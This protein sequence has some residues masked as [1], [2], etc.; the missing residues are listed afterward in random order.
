MRI[1][2]ESVPEEQETRSKSFDE[3]VEEALN[4]PEALKKLKAEELRPQSLLEKIIL[5]KWTAPIIGAAMGIHNF[6]NIPAES[7]NLVTVFILGGFGYLTASLSK[8][9]LIT[10]RAEDAPGKHR[11]LPSKLLH[12][13]SDHPELTAA[14]V[15]AYA[16]AA[17]VSPMYVSIFPS[18]ILKNPKFLLP[19]IDASVSVFSSVFTLAYPA[20]SF[21]LGRV[22]HPETGKTLV[23]AAAAAF[24]ALTYRHEKAAR[25]L[26][27]LAGVQRS[28]K[29]AIT[30]QTLIGDF[31]LLSEDKAYFEAFTEAVSIGKSYGPGRSDWLLNQFIRLLKIRVRN[32]KKP[33]WAEA[34]D[35]A[36]LRAAAYALSEGKVEAADSLLKSAVRSGE[37]SIVAHEARAG[38]LRRTG[39]QLTADLEMR[40][41]AELALKQESLD[42]EQVEGT[43]NRVLKKGR[44]VLKLNKEAA[45]LDAEQQVTRRFRER[46]GQEIIYPLPIFR[47]GSDY[48]LLSERDIPYS[49]LDLMMQRKARLEDFIKAQALLARVQKF[50]Y[51]LYRRGELPLDD[52][53]LRINFSEPETL[54][55][56]NRRILAMQ[57]VELHNGVKLPESYKDAIAR[58]LLFVDRRIAAYPHLAMSKDHN[59]G[60][61]LIS[62][63]GRAQLL[64][65]ERQSLRLMPPQTDA[66]ALLE[67]APY[68]SPQQIKWILGRTI[69]DFEHANGVKVDRDLFFLTYEDVAMQWHFERLIYRTAEAASAK[70]DAVREVKLEQQVR[71]LMASRRHLRTIVDE[72]YEEGTE[73]ESAKRALEQLEQPIFADRNEY[74]R[75]CR[76]VEREEKELLT[77]EHLP[78][79]NA[80]L[81]LVSGY[82][83][84]VL[85]AL[86]IG[87]VSIRNNLVPVANIPVNPQ[88]DK[89]MLAVSSTE[90]I[91]GYDRKVTGPGK[92]KSYVIDAHTDEVSFLTVMDTVGID[93]SAFQDKAAMIRNGHLTLYDFIKKEFRVVEDERFETP[94]ISPN[95]LWIA[96]TLMTHYF[97]PTELWLIRPSDMKTKRA[98]TFPHAFLPLP[99]K[100]SWSPD[101]TYL[102]FLSR[103]ENGRGESS[104]YWKVWINSLK[105]S[106]GEVHEGPLI[107]RTGYG[108]FAWSG[109]GRL[110][111]VIEEEKPG[112]RIQISDPELKGRTDVYI[113]RNRD[114]RGYDSET[115]DDIDFLGPDN[116]VIMSTLFNGSWKGGVEFVT[117]LLD[118]ESLALRDI[119]GPFMRDI[120]K[121]GNRL[122]FSCQ[123]SGDLCEFNLKTGRAINLTNTPNMEEFQAVY[124]PNGEKVYV[125][126]TATGCQNECPPSL[127]VVDLATGK[128]RL[129]QQEKDGSLRYDLIHP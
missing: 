129:L 124:S 76:I 55:H 34:H 11:A 41:R 27:N 38:F 23:N 44:L 25:S 70:N 21:L 8:R 110:A 37:S 83:V 15:A 121:D 74:Y 31:R 64:D 107:G 43:R 6:Y 36:Y 111:Y 7:G 69:S 39:R 66:V 51:D 45:P 119:P 22:V 75:L 35:L 112:Q 104:D 54:Y 99:F 92:V 32:A 86:T 87:A 20:A 40:I 78:A 128:S 72:R 14:G 42:F 113:T 1:K 58:C 90:E 12:L 100:V 94:Q 93:I 80:R 88:G 60:N 47:L 115:I 79:S 49:L 126:A 125:V 109:A 24:Y 84:G 71:H 67:F 120:S 68:L 61:A 62:T 26:T 127:F 82:A 29:T 33:A 63:T 17:L 52:A 56:A 85:A 18:Q 48:A 3:L 123:S 95:G 57:Q 9:D 5:S 118:L 16:T 97:Y 28:Y 13:F 108:L 122:L 2:D 73:L 106:T 53:I 117:S 50:G 89:I 77:R 46:F 101:G 4:S 102:A 96:S 59:P 114:M 103:N 10:R 30:L 91:G 98:T 19:A 116:L 65:F 81:A 105:V